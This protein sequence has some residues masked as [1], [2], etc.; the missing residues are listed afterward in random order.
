V[1]AREAVA[2]IAPA[3][4]GWGGTWVDIGAGDGT[5]TR[6]LA[7]LLEPRSRIFAV[8]TDA[9]A[10]AAV[11]QWADREGANVTPVVADF[12]RP[13]HLPGFGEQQLLDGMLAAN[14]LH[15]VQDPAG[16]LARLVERVRPGGRVVIIEYDR[17]RASP[18]VPYPIDGDRLLEI[19]ASA[20]LTAPTFT[21]TRPSLYGGA[22]YVAAMD[23]LGRQTAS[24]RSASFAQKPPDESAEQ[25]I[26]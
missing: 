18:W 24:V 13:I 15:F 12:T 26:G 2:L 22:I 7:Q 17:R 9:K 6:A 11:R 19:A 5:F 23:R 4:Q 3:V 20:G 14:A 21:A 25:E 1:N 8:D 10:L 16:V